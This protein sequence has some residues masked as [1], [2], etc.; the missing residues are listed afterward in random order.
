MNYHKY[1]INGFIILI[2]SLLLF[3]CA[4]RHK[5][6]L[7]PEQVS[8]PP[9]QTKPEPIAEKV[10]EEKETKAAQDIQKSESKEEAE[11]IYPEAPKEE[12]EIEPSEALEEAMGIYREALRAWD[13]GHIDDAISFLDSAYDLIYH[14]KLP[15]DSAL[16]QDKN[17]LRLLIAQRIQEIYA[18]RTG[19]LG[20][21]HGSIPLVENKYVLKEIK[22]FTGK[23]KKLFQ[24]AYK[25]SGQYREMILD[26]L[27][28]EGL[29]RELSWMPMIESWFKIRAYSRARALGLW[30]FISSTGYRFG[31]KRDRWID[32]RMDPEKST[33]AAVQYLKE[34]HSYFGDW[35]T[36]LAAYNCGEFRVQRIIRNQR[37]NYLDNFWDLYPMLPRETSRFVPRFI[38]AVFIVNDP[39]KFNMSLPTPDPPLN[40]Q[41]ITIRRPIKLS[42]L[43]TKMGLPPEKLADFN[44]ELRHKS[45]PDREYTL[46]VPAGTLEMASSVVNSLPRWIPPEA[47]Y[48]IHYVRRGET[49]SEIASR[50]GTSISSIARLNRLNRRYL[51]RPGQ[52]LKVPGSSRSR[53]TSVPSRNLSKQGNN[54]IYTVRRGDSLYLIANAFG[55]T[56]QNIKNLNNLNSSRLDVGQKLV[57][58]SGTPEGAVFYTVKA[59]D[60]PY[61]IARRFGMRLN[62]LLSINGLTKYSKIYPGQK[63][64]VTENK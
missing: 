3:N 31:L 16:I 40:Y 29:P 51:I 28:K 56:I 6:S 22:S 46:K 5:E 54:L 62:V 14:I 61:K 52:R 15:P 30:Q 42:T 58:Q 21:N 11:K 19:A 33:R 18:S 37:I 24:Q 43:S 50:Y 7:Q 38:A 13:Q 35:T 64:W 25:R 9:S 17:D 27:N 41:E 44:P 55:T 26:E 1:I 39:G 36:A 8:T 49:V 57:I 47:T 23:E 34:L 45:T 20:E 32:E 59:G 53:S 10:V 60:T 48:F 63:L 12:R 2:T 4:S